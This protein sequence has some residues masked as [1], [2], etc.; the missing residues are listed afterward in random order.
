[1][2]IRL[3]TSDRPAFWL[4]GD[5]GL[6]ARMEASSALTEGLQVTRNQQIVA[7]SDWESI[8]GVDR[9]NQRVVLTSTTRREFDSE[10]ARMIFIT[11]LAAVDS[12]RQLHRWAGNVFVR[13]DTSPVAFDEYN[14]PDSV[15][16]LTALVMEGAVGLKLTYQITAGG[17]G[18]ASGGF[19][20]GLVDLLAWDDGRNYLS[21]DASVVDARVND[22]FDDGA[23]FVRLERMVPRGNSP[24]IA[25]HQAVYFWQTQAQYEASDL[26]DPGQTPINAIGGSHFTLPS[27]SFF[28]TIWPYVPGNGS[29]ALFNQT[30]LTAE[31]VGDVLTLIQP[32]PPLYPSSSLRWQLTARQANPYVPGATLALGVQSYSSAFYAD[33][34]YNLLADDDGAICQLTALDE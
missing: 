27:S 19:G 6:S 16:A 32:S 31:I 2:R 14:L 21:F 8:L 7:G 12:A 13:I 28:S 4:V 20:E 1:M 33:E 3:E 30:G 29:V 10:Q 17:F 25:I 26:Y 15:V 24:F 5:P 34:E 23:V 9:G 11:A 22:F 18:D